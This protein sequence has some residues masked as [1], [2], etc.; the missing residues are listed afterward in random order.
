MRMSSQIL[1]FILVV[2]IVSLYMYYNYFNYIIV[3]TSENTPDN[4]PQIKKCS[5]SNL[6]NILNHLKNNQSQKPN[7]IMPNIKNKSNIS[8][9]V[10]NLIDE[11]NL[12]IEIPQKDSCNN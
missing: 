6:A 12:Q 5:N 7:L 1:I 11:N 2:I 3:N 8:D 10:E 9:R 4:K